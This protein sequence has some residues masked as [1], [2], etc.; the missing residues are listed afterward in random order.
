MVY[1]TDFIFLQ[2]SLLFL[3]G[4]FFVN[5]GFAKPLYLEDLDDKLGLFEINVRLQHLSVNETS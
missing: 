2:L 4:I 5:N 1:H 3:I